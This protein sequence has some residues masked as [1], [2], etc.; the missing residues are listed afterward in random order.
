M[1]NVWLAPKPNPRAIDIKRN[2][3]SSGSLIAVLNL[4]IDKAPT[5]PN[6]SANEDFIIVIISIVVSEMKIKFLLNKLLSERSI[7][8]MF[9][10]H[11]KV[12]KKLSN[13]EFNIFLKYGT[14]AFINQY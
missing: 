3:N 1:I 6:D 12:S 10:E 8:F 9:Q 13:L 2:I 5:N 11:K 7:A 4:I 14:I